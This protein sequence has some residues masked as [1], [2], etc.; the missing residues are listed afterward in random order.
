M[1]STSSGK[2]QRDSAAP[3]EV[4]WYGVEVE[5]V[6]QTAAATNKADPGEK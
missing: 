1:S 4:A 6:A 5:C 2:A 3:E